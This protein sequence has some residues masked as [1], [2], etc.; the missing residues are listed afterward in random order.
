MPD[1]PT[2]ALP[3]VLVNIPRGLLL[4]L[5]FGW[6]VFGYLWLVGCVPPSFIH[7]IPMTPFFLPL[8]YGILLPS[9][10]SHLVPSLPIYSLPTTTPLHCAVPL[11][12]SPNLN[13]WLFVF[14]GPYGWLLLN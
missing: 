12:S 13:T 8:P 5:A 11:G 7:S 10:P 4:V 14:A 2:Y 1:N 9:C 3:L 6:F